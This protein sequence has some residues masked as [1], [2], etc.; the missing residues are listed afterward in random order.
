MLQ[1]PEHLPNP[2]THT[3]SK[4]QPESSP[5]TT[6]RGSFPTVSTQ[7]FTI[8]SFKPSHSLN[9][10]MQWAETSAHFFG[11]CN[12]WT[13]YQTQQ[14]LLPELVAYLAN[15]L[16]LPPFAQHRHPMHPCG[17]PSYSLCCSTAPMQ[18]FAIQY[19]APGRSPHMPFII[20]HICPGTNTLH[21]W[22]HMDEYDLYLSSQEAQSPWS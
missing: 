18:H 9:I 16:T 21:L 1:P 4:L 15:F 20:S 17:L 8:F 5:Y 14:R 7:G 12:C 3:P 2:L 11:C 13:Y 10:F 22:H 6:S 19:V